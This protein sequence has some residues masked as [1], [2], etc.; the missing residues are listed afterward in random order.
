MGLI[1]TKWDLALCDQVTASCF[2]R[3][4]L[5]VVMVKSKMCGSVRMATKFVQQGHVRVGPEVVKDPAFLVT[6]YNFM[7]CLSCS[8]VKSDEWY[9]RDNCMCCSTQ[10]F[11]YFFISFS[12]PTE[13]G[14]LSINQPPGV[15]PL[16]SLL[17]CSGQIFPTEIMKY[18]NLKW[19]TNLCDEKYCTECKFVPRSCCSC[20]WGE[21]LSLKCNH[22]WA[23]C[24]S[25]RWLW[26]WRAMVEWYWQGNPENSET[27]HSATLSTTNPTAVRGWWLTTWAMAQPSFV[28]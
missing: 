25:L 26:V 5:P 15:L 4:R 14:Y 13:K 17:L 6:R 28:S 23:C 10:F 24:S 22:Q 20:W 11:F 8:F 7:W 16:M 3:R 9:T 21:T 1:P 12:P 2:C 19:S 18:Q 27:C